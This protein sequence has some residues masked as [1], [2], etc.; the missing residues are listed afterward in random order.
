AEFGIQ[1]AGRV[2]QKAAAVVV[3]VIVDEIESTEKVGIDTVALN[4]LR[5]EALIDVEPVDVRTRLRDGVY[6]LEQLIGRGDAADKPVARI[7]KRILELDPERVVVIVVVPVVLAIGRTAVGSAAQLVIAQRVHV[8]LPAEPDERLEQTVVVAGAGTVDRAVLDVLE[9]RVGGQTIGDLD[10]SVEQPG[11]LGEVVVRDVAG[12]VVASERDTR[13]GAI[14]S[15]AE[16][17][18]R[19]PGVTRVE[20]AL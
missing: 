5:S 4:V 2:D 12:D 14:R 11:G 17:N 1:I 8:H 9:R 18:R 16:R 7:L 3:A 6:T 13:A 19:R 10:R 20:E 15:A